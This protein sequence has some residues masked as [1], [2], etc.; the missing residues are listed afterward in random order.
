MGYILFLNTIWG[1]VPG[2]FEVCKENIAIDLGK[3][4]SATKLEV[5]DVEP[6]EG[7]LLLGNWWNMSYVWQF[8]FGLGLCMNNSQGQDLVQ[9]EFTVGMLEKTTQGKL[10]VWW[11]E[12]LV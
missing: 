8:T 10:L 6:C 2:L 3:Q 12:V 7:S 11:D 4:I 9:F 5:Y 1:S